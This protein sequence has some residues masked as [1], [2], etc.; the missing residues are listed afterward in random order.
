MD[1]APII[2]LA[3]PTGAGKTRAALELARELRGGVIN[4]D[5][6]QVYEDFPIVTAQPTAEERSV[7]PHLLY[8]FLSTSEKMPAGRFRQLAG[9]AIG[10]LAGQ[11][12]APL[13]V[14]GAGLYL[15]SLV[16]GLAP[17]PAVPAE[18]QARIIRQVEEEGPEAMHRK[19]S[20]VDPEYAGRIQR[21]DRQRIARALEVFEATGRTLSWWHQRPPGKSPRPA[22][23]AYLDLPI[24]ELEPLLSRRI[25]MMLEQGALEEI[26]RAWERCPDPEAPGWSG[27]GCAE[28]LE[29][30]RGRMSLA[31]AK[32]LWL[33][34]TRAYAKRQAT[35]FRKESN[36]ERFRAGDEGEIQRLA[37]RAR[38]FLG[39]HRS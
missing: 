22:F 2:V 38:E 15:R 19:L 14:G 11:G 7:C 5:S 35:W 37:L 9:E 1:A 12:L 26:A 24:G 17:I 32:L 3:G 10:Q 4:G 21:T 33:R 20:A 39:A 30:H 16:E 27:I 36:L 6:R 23:K 18:V 25:E 8:G 31:E 13:V 34:K 29:Y 28:L